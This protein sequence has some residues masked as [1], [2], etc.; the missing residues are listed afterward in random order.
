MI[1]FA[2]SSALVKLY[3]D[4]LG[5][6]LVR[7][8]A[9]LVVSQLCRVEVPAAL[10]R[11]QRTGEITSAEASD[12]VAEFEADYFGTAAEPARFVA[13][14]VTADVLDTAARATGTYGLRAYD[15]VQLGSAMLAREAAPEIAAVLAWDGELRDAAARERFTVQP[16]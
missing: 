16:D 15:A 1:A 8:H 5:H 9:T 7:S 10:W 12:L 14:P 2:D 13:V 4:E 3:A 11:K 6:E